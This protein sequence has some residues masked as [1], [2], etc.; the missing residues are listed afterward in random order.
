MAKIP[1][2]QGFGEV[3]AQPQRLSGTLSAGAFGGQLANNMERVGGQMVD[4][5][6]RQA[7]EQAERAR[8]LREAADKANALQTMQNAELDLQDA[9]DELSERVATGQADKT[10][11]GSDWGAIINDK[12]ATASERAPIA[13][14]QTIKGSLELTA[15]RLARNVVGKAVQTRD[16]ED[17]RAGLLSY[18]ETQERL[19]VTNPEGATEAAI[20]AIAELGPFAGMGADDIQKAAFGFRERVASNTANA[21]VRSS[22][23]SMA[24]LDA[25]LER[26]QGEAFADLTPERRGALENQIMARKSYLE[27]RE[28]TRIARAEAAAA[29]RSREAE[30]SFNAAQAIIDS[31]GLPSPEYLDQVSSKTAGTPYGAALRELLTQSTE[32]AG[33]AQLPPQRQREQI[34]QMRAEANTQGT[35]PQLEKRI[36]TM[37]KIATD[38]QRQLDD[39]PLMW[40][41]NRR[42]LDQVQPID[43]TNLQNLPAQLASRADQAATVAARAGRPVSPLLKSEAEQLAQSIGALPVSQQRQF[44]KTLARS[45]DPRQAQALAAQISPKDDTLGLAMFLSTTATRAPQDPAELILRGAD[46]I[47][48]GRL[49]PASADTAA[50]DA[51]RRIA[52]D[53]SEVNW[54]TTQARDAAISAAQ[55][56]YDGL[57]D[58]GGASTRKAIE[59]ATGGLTE[60]NGAQV[61]VP[62][63]MNEREFKRA[64]RTLDVRRVE[65]QA[66]GP[67]VKVGGD[68][69][70]VG[71]LVENMGAMR[72]IPAGPGAYALESGGIL[73]TKG[74]GAPLR[75]TVGD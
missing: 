63:G 39:D 41:V 14:Q 5:E 43:V 61:P 46:A 58:A 74:N 48:S 69:L 71:K 64:L 3:I 50:R 18:L 65:E 24:G 20:S 51:H 35:T 1:S 29:R 15:R 60:W 54:A 40:G 44:V 4:Q 30:S 27:T 68:W 17:T 19:A 2:G 49:K 62:Y 36:S 66:G 32:R 72:L 6:R 57:R 37:E 55:K 21:L 7:A 33:F 22:S 13:H 53:L 11:A 52:D 56:T 73:V 28:Q 45:M 9:A 47:K 23:T 26:L 75:I 67:N 16:R 25:A 59:L 8:M 70:G 12:I 31:G 10:T 34:L 38:S 42:L